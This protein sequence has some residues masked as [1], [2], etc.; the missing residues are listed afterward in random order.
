LQTKETAEE[1]ERTNEE[2]FRD[3]EY[4]VRYVCT[5]AICLFACRCVLS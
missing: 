2:V 1:V 5:G 4:Q 3:R